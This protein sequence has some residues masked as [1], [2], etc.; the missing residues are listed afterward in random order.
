[1]VYHL[2]SRFQ[3]AILGQKIA[4]TLGG[5][6]GPKNRVRALWT[7]SVHHWTHFVHENRDAVPQR[8]LVASNARV[9]ARIGS[10]HQVLRAVT[11]W[12]FVAPPR[13]ERERDGP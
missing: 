4:S 12:P 6:G 10:S 1:M 11:N 2:D 13:T 7:Q 9:E 8:A 5:V 3:L